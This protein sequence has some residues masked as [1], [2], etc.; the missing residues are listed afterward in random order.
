MK[1][2][3]FA[4]TLMFLA[5]LVTGSAS[6]TLSDGLV[7]HWSFDRCDARDDSGHGYDGDMQGAPECVS[8]VKGKALHFNKVDRDN[9]CG[10]PGGDYILIP[11]IQAV[12]NSGFTVCAWA[13]FEEFRYHEKI[14][15]LGNARGELGGLPVTFGRLMGAP[16]LF[17]ESWI[18]SDGSESRTTG[19]ISGGEIVNGTFRFYCGTINNSTKSMTLYV[20]GDQVQQKT[21][22]QIMN[23]PRTLNFIGH[24][25]WCDGDPDFKGTLDEIYLYN[26]ALS[27]PEIMAL[28]VIDTAYQRGADQCT[29]TYNVTTG[30]VHMP[31]FNLSNTIFW[32]DLIPYS[33]GTPTLLL[34]V[35]NYGVK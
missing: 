22:H 9:G 35:T 3:V 32:L 8:G 25:Q 5:F 14:M 13:K 34:D 20:D 23:V 29:A 10:Q 24:S 1:K 17:M 2:M 21:G 27:A 28:Y 16:S 12:W 15:D 31:C 33:G 18:N 6:A 11:I 26:R 4:A 7:A 30:I 19:R